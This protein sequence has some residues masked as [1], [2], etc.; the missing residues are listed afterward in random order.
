M[1]ATVLGVAA[2]ALA[3]ATA[4]A[5]E[6]AP[7]WGY[8]YIDDNPFNDPGAAGALLPAPEVYP[9]GYIRDTLVD[10]M[11]VRL[12]V[13]VFTPGNDHPVT[14][15]QVNEGDFENIPIDRRLDIAPFEVGYVRYELCNIDPTT[16]VAEACEPVLRI[17]R[18]APPPAPT[19]VPAA[20]VDADSDGVPAGADC[21]DQNATVHP[22][23]KEIPGNGLDDDC[24]G[25]DAPGRLPATFRNKWTAA[26]GR[27]RVD[28]LRVL[29]AP[30][31][32]RVEVRLQRQAL[33]VPAQEGD[34]RER[35]GRRVPGQVLQAPPA[36]ADDH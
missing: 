18:P 26:H 17:S 31:G 16:G 9:R 21:W 1:I 25:G 7:G 5:H 23:A 24:T 4:Q 13:N 30:E 14:S 27:V 29:D 28:A 32:A 10:G 3:C 36:P 15:Y 2:S 34:E 33:P 22:G 8:G 20:P 19:P 35:Q 6:F 12:S 11:D